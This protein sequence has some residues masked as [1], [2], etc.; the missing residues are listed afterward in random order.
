MLEPVALHQTGFKVPGL[1][2]DARGIVVSE[3][4]LESGRLDEVFRSITQ[5]AKGAAA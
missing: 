3:L 4:Q 2:Q 1:A 5:P